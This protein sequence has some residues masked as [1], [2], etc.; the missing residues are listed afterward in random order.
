[1]LIQICKQQCF[2]SWFLVF[3]SMWNICILA[4]SSYVSVFLPCKPRNILSFLAYRVR[5]VMGTL[6][7]WEAEAR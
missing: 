4:W 2:P 5:I 7:R 1:V 6:P 3:I